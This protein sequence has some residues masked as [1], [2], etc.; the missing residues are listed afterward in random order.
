M[1]WAYQI[2]G[3]LFEVELEDLTSFKCG[4]NEVLAERFS[5][6]AQRTNWYLDGYSLI[7]SDE[8]L[9]ADL[10]RSRINAKVARLLSECERQRAISEF[11]LKDYHKFVSVDAHM[12]IIRSTRRIRA[13][14][15]GIDLASFIRKMSDYLNTPLSLINPITGKEHYAIARINQPRSNNFNPVHKD[16]YQVYDRTGY[17]PGMINIWIPVSGVGSQSGLSVAPGSHLINE[18]I[19]RRT[20]AGSQM[21]GNR[22][23]VAS[24]LDW[25]GD[26]CLKTVAPSES[27]LLIFSSHLLHGLGFNASFDSTRIAFE[28]RLFADV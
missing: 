12:E 15:L 7:S 17:I 4:K 18:N 21:N 11:S 10:L 19:I 26:R 16:I 13:G 25:G 5:Y 2:D 23:S 27:Q 3:E 22:Y 24:V 14:D 6:L 20:P 8:F 28:L 9:N 1:K